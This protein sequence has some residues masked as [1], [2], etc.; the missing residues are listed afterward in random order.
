MSALETLAQLRAGQRPSSCLLHS[1]R[2]H[3]FGCEAYGE[4]AIVERFRTMP[5]AVAGEQHVIVAPGH[6]ALFAG[7]GAMIADLAGENITR[8]WRVGP[9]AP[10]LP[11]AG[12]SV[13]FDPDLTQARGDVFFCAGDHRALPADA[14]DRVEAIGRDLARSDEGARARAFAIRAFGSAHEGAALFALYRLSGDPVRACGFVHAAVRWAGDTLVIVRDL[15][16]EAAVAATP[17]TPRIGA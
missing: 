15:A 11:E 7:A 12:V 16:G 5:H 13:V 3:A 10:V 2:L 1:C 14:A 6:I 4:E 9:G 17:W 8:I